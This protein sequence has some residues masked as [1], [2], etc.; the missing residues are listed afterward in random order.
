MKDH[1]IKGSFCKRYFGSEKEAT[2]SVPSKLTELS[3][4]IKA[5]KLIVNGVEF[6]IDEDSVVQDWYRGFSLSG[7]QAAPQTEEEKEKAK[8]QRKAA[9]STVKAFSQMDKANQLSIIEKLEASGHDCSAMRT[10]FNLP[11]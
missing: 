5:G 11:K 7:Q 2:I 3:A 6:K 10:A 1:K 9:T 4:A 8:I